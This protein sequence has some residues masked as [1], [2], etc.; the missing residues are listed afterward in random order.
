MMRIFGSAAAAAL[1][2]ATAAFLAARPAAAQDGSVAEVAMVVGDSLALPGPGRGA[3]L[4]ALPVG[5][6]GLL[7]D[8]VASDHFETTN[9]ARWPAVVE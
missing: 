7:H 2:M 5:H 4:G 1:L 9:T 3:A 6:V 8:D